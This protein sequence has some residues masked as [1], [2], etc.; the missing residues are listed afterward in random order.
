MSNKNFLF[1]SESVTEGH[2]DKVADN[3]SD[4]ILDE[5]IANELITNSAKHAYPADESG[6]VTVTLS[7]L[8]G[9]WRLSVTDEGAG[10]PEEVA[11][12]GVGLRLVRSLVERAA[13]RLEVASQN[14]FRV[15]VEIPSL[16]KV[17]GPGQEPHRA[18]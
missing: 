3:I 14:G 8:P 13:G 18:G 17:D 10:C 11:R 12:P 15:E 9:A 1:S 16:E 6:R 7:S 5:I 4:A 2:P